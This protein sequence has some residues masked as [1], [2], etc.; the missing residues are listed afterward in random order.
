MR[1]TDKTKENNDNYIINVEHLNKQF[2]V[3]KQP[4]EVLR[5]INLQ[6]KKVNLSQL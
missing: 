3:D 6:I 5:D 1:E 2:V 4:M